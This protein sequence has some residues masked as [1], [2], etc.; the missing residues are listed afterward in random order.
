MRKKK[1][2]SFCKA[3]GYFSFSSPSL[4]HMGLL[5]EHRYLNSI[6]VTKSIAHA[7]FKVLQIHFLKSI[8]HIEKNKN[9]ESK[10]LNSV[11]PDTSLGKVL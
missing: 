1:K 10:Q 2:K 8:K 7:C 4:H 5:T 3:E 6:W 9:P 11:Q